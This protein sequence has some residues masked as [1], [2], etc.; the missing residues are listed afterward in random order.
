[1]SSNQNKNTKTDLRTFLNS[2]LY[3]ALKQELDTYSR[4]GI[5]LKLQGRPSNS[6]KIA[7]TCSTVRESHDSYMRD[8]ISDENGVIIE[9]NFQKIRKV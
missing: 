7:K 3:N 1:M 8:F 6:C 5:Q 4:S 2:D 9:I